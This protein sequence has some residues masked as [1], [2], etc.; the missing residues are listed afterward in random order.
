VRLPRGLNAPLGRPAEE[1]RKPIVK[2]ELKLEEEEEA[3]EEK[4]TEAVKEGKPVEAVEEV[5]GPGSS[6]VDPTGGIPIQVCGEASRYPW[7]WAD[8]GKRWSLRR[9]CFSRQSLES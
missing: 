2:G 6:R 7:G 1:A 4:P 3:V 5:E 8:P 9:C